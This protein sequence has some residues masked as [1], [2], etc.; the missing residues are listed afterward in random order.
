MKSSSK[1]DGKNNLVLW[2]RKMNRADKQHGDEKTEY[3]LKSSAKNTQ[4]RGQ[5]FKS[6]VF[7]GGQWALNSC[8]RVNIYWEQSGTLNH[9]EAILYD[10]KLGIS[11]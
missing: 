11:F 10:R 8:P 2:C 1:E 3:H 7:C 4:S 6:L 5:P 9:M